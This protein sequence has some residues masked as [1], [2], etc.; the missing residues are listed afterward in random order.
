MCVCVC[1]V[2]PSRDVVLARRRRLVTKSVRDEPRLRP[3]ETRV[4][5]A[6]NDSKL[7]DGGHCHRLTVD[8]TGVDGEH[9]VSARGHKLMSTTKLAGQAWRGTKTGTVVTVYCQ[10]SVERESP[11]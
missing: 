7:R 9:R 6:A 11:T 4:L 5:N 2:E 3:D 1:V 8:K 10:R